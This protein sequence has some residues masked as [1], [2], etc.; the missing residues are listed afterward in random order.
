MINKFSEDEVKLKL[1]PTENNDDALKFLLKN[2]SK[3][4]DWVSRS[5]TEYSRLIENYNYFK[6]EISEEN[7]QVAEMR[8]NKLMFVEISLD[9][10]NDDPQKIFES[11]NSMGLPLSE[12]DLI[13]NYILMGLERNDQNKLYNDYWVVIQKNAKETAK[14][15]SRVSDF[16]RDYLTIKTKKITNKSKVYQTFKE[17]FSDLEL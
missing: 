10:K 16:I 2:Y 12:A 8:L 17:N 7:Y 3:E 15:A 14:N 5:F 4:V 13:R 1:R 6:K 11:L 9:R